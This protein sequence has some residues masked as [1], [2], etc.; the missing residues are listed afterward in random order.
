MQCEWKLASTL[1]HLFKGEAENRMWGPT[2]FLRVGIQ[3]AG[4]QCPGPPSGAQ[5]LPH[6]PPPR[7]AKDPP[8]CRRG[9]ASSDGAQ[10]TVAA[11]TMGGCWPGRGRYV[12]L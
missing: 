2:S 12:D 1:K 10:G 5:H 3:L 7:S 8:R 9:A 6:T 4:R 11:S